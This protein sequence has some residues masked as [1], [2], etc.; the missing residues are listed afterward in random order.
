[1]TLEAVPAALP[2]IV[3]PRPPGPSATKIR[4]GFQW[5]QQP[6][7]PLATPSLI[8]PM[9]AAPELPIA[10]MAARPRP[11]KQQPAF[12]ER[13]AARPVA[14]H[15]V[16]VV[17][18]DE[19]AA[20]RRGARRRRDEADDARR[21]VL[22]HPAM[23]SAM[24][25]I[26]DVACDLSPRVEPLMRALETGWGG[27]R[28][29]KNAIHGVLARALEV[30]LSPAEL[31]ALLVYLR[32]DGATGAISPSEFA[33]RFYSLVSAERRRRRAAERERATRFRRY[34]A[35]Y[36]ARWVRRIAPRTETRVVWPNLGVVP[37]G[38]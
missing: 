11:P 29:D 28:L 30:K 3:S 4:C 1:M 34:E 12:H 36:K 35:G 10:T 9:T 18:D 32:V 8:M 23:R 22:R 2:P 24:R 25:K 13:A 17:P 26:G 21:A 7:P 14:H 33:A 16:V 38:S 19:T 37:R 6:Q 27:S 15:R 5:P 31:G 20:G